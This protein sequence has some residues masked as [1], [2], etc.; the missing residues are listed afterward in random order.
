MNPSALLRL[1]ALPLALAASSLSAQTLLNED[2]SDTE[3]ATQNLTSSSAWNLLTGTA[4]IG[5]ATNASNLS[6]SSGGLV[7]TQPTTGT[8]NTGVTANLV[9]Y[10]TTAGSPRALA[11]G[12]TLSVSFTLAVSALNSST[13]AG[14]FRFGL[15]D[16]GATSTRISADSFGSGGGNFT[17]SAFTNDGGYTIGFNPGSTATGVT[18]NERNAASVNAANTALFSSNAAVTTT[19]AT[20]SLAIGAT[21]A[22]PFSVSFS[23][24]RVGTSYNLSSTING[25]TISFTDTSISAS[26]FDQFALQYSSTSVGTPGTITLDNLNIGVTSAI[27]EPSSFAALAGLGALGL[28]A[29]R[30]R[31]AA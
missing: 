8:A 4:A 27:P 20:S 24:A 28:V 6:A 22:T 2:F 11:D 12:E 3:R 18:I 10:F 31:R 21:A 26:A 17:N 1:S 15:F 9:T 30:R 16:S 13:A 23:I 5:G 25:Q 14:T 7:Y 19:I 29:T